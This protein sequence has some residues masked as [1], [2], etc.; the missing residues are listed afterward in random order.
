LA[1]AQEYA[2]EEKLRN[3]KRLQLEMELS[4]KVAPNRPS[5]VIKWQ[6]WN[7]VNMISTSPVSS[8][9]TQQ[10]SFRLTELQNAD[11][12]R[13]ED[14]IQQMDVEDKAAVKAG[15]LWKRSSNVR[16]DWKRRWFFIQVR[17]TL[18]TIH[19]DETHMCWTCR[20]GNFSTKELM[21]ILSHLKRFAIL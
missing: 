20:A 3:A 19:C 4:N 10:E 13:P 14:P 5:R 12:D 18:L 16:R 15:Y 7:P 6:H 1:Y 8:V 11:E 17:S 21:S 2:R 9:V